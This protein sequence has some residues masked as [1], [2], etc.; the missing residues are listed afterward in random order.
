MACPYDRVCPLALSYA[1]KCSNQC[2]H[3]YSESG[4]G[5]H[6]DRR[7]Y[8]IESRIKSSSERDQSQHEMWKKNKR[9]HVSEKSF[10][11]NMAESR[12][13]GKLKNMAFIGMFHLK[14]IHQL[15]R[16]VGLM[17]NFFRD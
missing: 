4:H 13:V 2:E 15:L 14:F 8:V 17:Q 3:I 11:E 16:R 5:K 10:D 9:S 1:Y 12:K 6:V 7:I